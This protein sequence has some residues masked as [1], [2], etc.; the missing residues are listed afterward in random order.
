MPLTLSVNSVQ[1]D[2][3]QQG[4]TTAGMHDSRQQ[5]LAAEVARWSHAPV[6]RIEGSAD[7]LG[8]RWPAFGHTTPRKTG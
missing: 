1:Q 7:D 5:L 3:Q 4:R 6:V 8:L 2:V